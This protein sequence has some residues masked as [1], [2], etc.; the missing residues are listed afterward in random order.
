MPALTAAAVRDN[1]GD[2]SGA[3]HA[4]SVPA[5]R[6]AS[7]HEAAIEINRLTADRGGGE[8][9]DDQT[10]APPRRN[11]RGAPAIAPAPRSRRP[12]PGR[13]R[14]A[15]AGRFRPGARFRGNR[16]RR[17]Q[18]WAGRKP[19]PRAELFGRPSRRDGSTAMWARAQTRRD[20]VDMAEPGDAGL[21]AP[22]SAS[23]A[24]TEAG[25]AGSGVPAISSSTREPRR[26]SSS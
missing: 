12:K 3:H 15:R 13:R 22:S 26:R 19:R 11:A 4:V 16:E 18:S 10:C 24:L 1:K 21:P 2:F 5:P 14:T 8:A 20:V 23:C 25:L 9:L 6:P 17:S 7:S